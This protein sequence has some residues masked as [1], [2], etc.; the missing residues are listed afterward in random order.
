MINNKD[1]D[2]WEQD[3]IAKSEFFHHKLHDWG[4]LEIAYELEGIEGENIDWTLEKLNISIKAWNKTIHRGIKPIRLFVH[5]EIILQNPKRIAYYRML[6]M[7][8]QKSMSRV[9]ISLNRYEAK[10][11]TLDYEMATTIVKH[12]NKIICFLIEQDKII[13]SREFDIWRGMTAGSQAQGSWQNTKGA[14]VEFLI[15][16]LII[17]RVHDKDLVTGEEQHGKGFIFILN[18]GRTL[19]FGTEP[20][21]GIFKDDLIQV[22]IEIKGGIDSAGVL[23]RFGAVLKSLRRAKQLNP[24]SKTILIIPGTSLTVTV[25]QEL[26]KSKNIIDYFFSLE[27]ILIN[28]QCRNK[29]FAIM[30]I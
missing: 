28:N 3:Q 22:A 21:V 1:K 15:K 16:E 6:A 30:N 17:D 7:V 18:D 29:L 27:D 20:D 11:N 2:I 24:K 26:E 14:K 19:A 4:L 25:H 5:P 12:L 23:E 13:D 10:G 9:G 8:S